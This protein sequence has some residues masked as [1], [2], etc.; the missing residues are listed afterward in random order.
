MLPH[1]EIVIERADGV[2]TVSA[3]GSETVLDLPDDV[4]RHI[5]V[6]TASGPSAPSERRSGSAAGSGSS[7]SA[8]IFGT[9]PSE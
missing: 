4:A 8:V 6:G 7:G 2:V 5:F 1:R 9:A 3:P